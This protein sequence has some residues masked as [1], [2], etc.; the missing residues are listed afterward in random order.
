[1]SGTLRLK[2]STSGYSELQA[3]AVAGDQ[4]FI[5]PA[6][7]GN[8]LTTDNPAPYLTLE[9]GVVTAPSLRF[10]GDLDTG[11]YTPAAN[12]IGITTNS[13]ERLRIDSAGNVGIGTDSPSTKLTIDHTTPIDTTNSAIAGQLGNIYLEMSSGGTQGA[14]NLGPS[15]NFTGINQSGVD[16]RKAAIVAQQTGA[17]SSQ[18]GLSFW[19]NNASDSSGAIQNR[20][21]IAANGRVGIGTTSPSKN[22][23]VAGEIRASSG[24]LFGT[25]TAAANTLDDYEEGT[26]TPSFTT[27]TWT[28]TNRSGYYTKV[29][30][31]VTAWLSI[32]WG[33]RPN[34]Q[35]LKIN[36]PFTAATGLEQSGTISNNGQYNTGAADVQLGC[37]V[38]SGGSNLLVALLRDGVSR[39]TG[40]STD[41]QL[42]TTFTASISYQI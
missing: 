5:F 27:G 35:N 11:L 15:I 36:L 21:V 13:N 9:S 23:D 8:L 1:M 41:F 42:D 31:T 14:E 7:G 29:G 19:T 28:Y 33:A 10:E 26:W 25:D 22:L 18:V 30:N 40:T 3:P 34:G 37:Y 16:G 38:A 6:V 20:M 32:S 17:N 24:I 39:V 4:T 2:G 12:E